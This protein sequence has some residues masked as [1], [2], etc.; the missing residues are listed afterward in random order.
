[1]EPAEQA[2]PTWR[3]RAQAP[4][5]GTALG[6]IADIGAGGREYVFGTGLNAFRMFVIRQGA[7]LFGYLNLCPHYSLPLNVRENEFLARD[8]RRI[9]CR[10]HLAVFQVE[11]GLCIDG[12]C[13]GSKL[14]P[15]PLRVDAAGLVVIG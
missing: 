4:A 14:D 11:D 6:P 9:M 15:V 12:A 8:G 5:P 1:M 10:R 7:Q 2:E 3:L 13:V